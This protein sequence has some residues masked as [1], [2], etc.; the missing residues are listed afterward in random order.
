M[1]M[2]DEQNYTSGCLGFLGLLWNLVFVWAFF[3]VIYKVL[4]SSNPI[5]RVFVWI[6]VALSIYVFCFRK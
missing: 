6:Y 4:T 5:V 1:N 3:Y 2:K